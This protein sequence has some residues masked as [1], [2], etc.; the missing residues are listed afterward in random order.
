MEVSSEWGTELVYKACCP[1]RLEFLTGVG[2]KFFAH[3]SFVCFTLFSSLYFSNPFFSPAHF[4]FVCVGSALRLQGLQKETTSILEPFVWLMSFPRYFAVLVVCPRPEQERAICVRRFR[5][6]AFHP[7]Q[8]T[9]AET[10]RNQ[11]P[12]AGHHSI[13]V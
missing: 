3:V 4:P 6:V 11:N 5:R 8:L 12:G 1:L 10:L 7:L 2:V 13:V 9:R